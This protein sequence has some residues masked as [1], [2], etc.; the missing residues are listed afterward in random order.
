MKNFTKKLLSFTAL[1]FVASFVNSA[2]S[3]DCSHTFTMIDTYG[4]GWN[5]NAVEVFVNGVSALD[6]NGNTL[7]AQTFTSGSSDTFNFMASPNDTI[8][9]SWTQGSYSSEVRWNIL[10]CNGSTLNSGSYGDSLEVIGCGSEVSYSYGNNES[11]VL[12]EVTAP[13][14]QYVS[15][16]LGGDVE[17]GYDFISIQDGEGNVLAESMT[18]TLAEDLTGSLSV[19]MCQLKVQLLSF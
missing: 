10:D 3:Q 8:T 4:D 12:Y 2:N 6:S 9:L 7:G 18:G 14:G 17:N 5:G 1:F 16:T 19:L 13:S 15:V 11:G